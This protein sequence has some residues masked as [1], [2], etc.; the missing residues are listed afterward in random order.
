MRK[1]LISRRGWICLSGSACLRLAVR[2]SRAVGGLKTSSKRVDINRLT[3]SVGLPAATAASEKRN[4]HRRKGKNARMVCLRTA[5]KPAISKGGVWINMTFRSSPTPLACAAPS[6]RLP[7][8]HPPTPAPVSLP[9]AGG[10]QGK[11]GDAQK[12]GYGSTPWP[13][14]LSFP[15]TPSRT[16]PP[17]STDG[18]RSWRPSRAFP[19]SCRGPDSS[20][21]GR[22]TGRRTRSDSPA[23]SRPESPIG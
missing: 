23:F 10:G 5:G 4:Q 11:D 9:A 19:A 3:A 14:P 1:H 18:R 6:S 22:C 15:L 17:S 2:V 21:S 7:L 8:W 16:T 20:C 12:Q 13:C